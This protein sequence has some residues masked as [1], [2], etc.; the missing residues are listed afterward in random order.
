M[1]LLHDA[2][3]EVVHGGLG[4]ELGDLAAVVIA[5][6]SLVAYNTLMDMGLDFTPVIEW[7]ESIL[8]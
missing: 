4:E 5:V 2:H 3:W 8:S 7:L 6:P 1:Q